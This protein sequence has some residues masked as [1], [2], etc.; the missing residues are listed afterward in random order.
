M[1]TKISIGLLAIVVFAGLYFVWVPRQSAGP[2]QTQ[3]AKAA[4]ARAAASERAAQVAAQ[5]RADEKQKRIEAAYAELK[6]DRDKLNRKLGL[7]RTDVWGLKLPR[8]Q[9]DAIE[10]KLLNG[11]K[12]LKH[13]PLLGAFSSV[14]EIS[15]ERA[16]VQGALDDLAQIEQELK[17]TNTG[18]LK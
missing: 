16:K 13:P 3:T 1:K 12:L 2:R 7:V 10:D 4:A 6:E 11:Y 8:Q 15:E 14:E 18:K 5:R 17:K 9:A